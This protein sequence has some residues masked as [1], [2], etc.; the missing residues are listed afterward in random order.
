MQKQKRVTVKCRNPLP[1][2]LAGG[3]YEVQKTVREL[4]PEVLAV[5][6]SAGGGEPVPLETESVDAGAQV[7]FLSEGTGLAHRRP[8]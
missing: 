1:F 6:F 5:R 3:L 7:V 8:A 2:S 4:E